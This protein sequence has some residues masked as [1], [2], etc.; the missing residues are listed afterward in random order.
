MIDI[1]KY[2]IIIWRDL[3]NKVSDKRTLYDVKC[4]KVLE[5]EL[6]KLNVEKHYIVQEIH[7]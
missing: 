6:D 3:V 5:D 2:M 1:D 4:S 7:T